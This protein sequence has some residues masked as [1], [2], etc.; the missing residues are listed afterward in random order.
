M[1]LWTGLVFGLHFPIWSATR[2][3]GVVGQPAVDGDGVSGLSEFRGSVVVPWLVAEGVP[4]PVRAGSDVV[5]RFPIRSVGLGGRAA[6]A[7][8]ASL[9]GA[10][11][12]LMCCG[13]RCGHGCG[14]RD[15]VHL[16]GLD[17]FSARILRSSPH[18]GHPGAVRAV[19]DCCGASKSL[20]FRGFTTAS[21]LVAG[22]GPVP[23]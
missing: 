1:P 14:V 6:G 3:V 18:F 17:R 19:V 15:G 21:Q 4:I 23:A 5:A 7:P 8:A 9:R 13:L 10:G 22:C 12:W 20:G 11:R 16:C 2:M